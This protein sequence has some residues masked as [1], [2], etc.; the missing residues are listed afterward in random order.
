MF[1]CAF[2]IRTTLK[3]LD[4]YQITLGNASILVC[5]ECAQAFRNNDITLSGL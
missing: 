5:P 3:G 2:H 4:V 1:Y